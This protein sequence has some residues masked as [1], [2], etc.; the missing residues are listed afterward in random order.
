MTHDMVPP[1]LAV[2]VLLLV[3]KLARGRRNGKP[4][5]LIPQSF[6]ALATALAVAALVVASGLA[7][8]QPWDA[9]VIPAVA[10]GGLVG[11]FVDLR[12]R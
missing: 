11:S 3:I 10:L 12:H 6:P 4:S 9:S 7:G 1:L 8:G 2:A 5:P